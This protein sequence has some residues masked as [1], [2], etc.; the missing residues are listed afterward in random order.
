MLPVSADSRRPHRWATGIA[1]SGG[2]SVGADGLPAVGMARSEAPVVCNWMTSCTLSAAKSVRSAYSPMT[3]CWL[4]WRRSSTGGAQG[5]GESVGDVDYHVP[6]VLLAG[7]RN[8]ERALV[9]DA[10]REGCLSLE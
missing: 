5:E 1:D 4:R 6:V 7:I 2:G 8:P 3:G 10:C 9:D